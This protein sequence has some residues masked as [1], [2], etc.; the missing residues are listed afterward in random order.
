MEMDKQMGAYFDQVPL[1]GTGLDSAADIGGWLTSAPVHALV[2]AFAEDAEDRELVGDLMAEKGD[3]AERLARLDVFTDRWDT[4]QGLERNQ[5]AELPLSPDQEELALVAAEALG[6]C[7]GTRLRF[8]Q[9]DHVLMLGGLIRACLVRTA[10]AAHLIRSGQIIA[11]SVTALG[12]HRPFVGDE[13]ALAA[14]AGAPEL[15]EEYEAMDFGTRRAFGL[16]EPETVEGEES[17][18]PGGT[19]GVRR[20]RTVEG[21]PVQ[22]VAAPSSEP[23]KRRADTPD[24]YAFF[25]DQIAA[26][27]PRERLLLVTTPIYVPAQHAA[28]V[29]MLKLPYGVEVDT[30]GNDPGLVE[31]APAQKFSATKYL[32]EVRSTVR[33]LRRLEDAIR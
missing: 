31:G 8:D 27:R 25:A 12:G 21:V 22:V 19:W 7:G 32:L 9:Y 30:V 33:S 6:M 15:S 16:G 26:L 18:L 1:V 13:F 24:S 11:G 10:Y 4:R 28:A 20:Y 3:V 2:E 17:P 29:R 5:A 14:E 23:E